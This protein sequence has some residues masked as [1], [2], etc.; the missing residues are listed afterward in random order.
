MNEYDLSPITIMTLEKLQKRFPCDTEAEIIARAI[1][2]FYDAKYCYVCC[3]TCKN[4]GYTCA[5]EEDDQ[6]CDG[7]EFWEM[8]D[9]L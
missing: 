1:G 8:R 7:E 4:Y 2:E 5:G 6:Y 3:E 9:D